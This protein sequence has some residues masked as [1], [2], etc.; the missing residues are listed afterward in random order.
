LGAVSLTAQAITNA[1]KRVVVILAAAV[2][3]GRPLGASSCA[4]VLM[5]V[6]G[7]WGYQR[8]AV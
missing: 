6:L 8:P 5:A 2:Y 4:G 3:F 1:L 7:A